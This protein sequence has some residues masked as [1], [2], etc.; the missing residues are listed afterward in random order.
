M[1]SVPAQD[2]A[3]QK[4]NG[5]YVGESRETKM[6]PLDDQ[7]LMPF[8][9]HEGEPMGRVPVE[10]LNYLWQRLKWDEFGLVAGYIRR[11]LN[12]LKQKNPN[13]KW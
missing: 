4:A 2:R 1:A 8:G 3:H 13:L 10:H 9:Q 11:N 12:W 5:R 7:S 6:K